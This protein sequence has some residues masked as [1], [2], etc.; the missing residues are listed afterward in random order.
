MF[1]EKKRKYIDCSS[2]KCIKTTMRHHFTSI[3]MSTA[4]EKKKQKRNVGEAVEEVEPSLL[5]K[6]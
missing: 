1:V 5:V 6:M 4:K 3:R 2:R